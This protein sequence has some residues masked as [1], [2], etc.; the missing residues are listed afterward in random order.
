VASEEYRLNYCKIK[1]NL[2]ISSLYYKISLKH[3]ILIRHFHIFTGKGIWCCSIWLRSINKNLYLYYIYYILAFRF[4]KTHNNYLWIRKYGI[5]IINFE[6][7]Y[8]IHI[9]KKLQKNSWICAINN[10]WGCSFCI[11]Y[12]FPTLCPDIYNT[13][14]CI[15]QLQLGLCTSNVH[16]YAVNRHIYI[17]P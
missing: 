2:I 7:Y 15:N 5:I 16:A 3:N 17:Q 4:L 11:I 9:G 12:S 14:L 1:L 6:A 13:F 10:K 8:T